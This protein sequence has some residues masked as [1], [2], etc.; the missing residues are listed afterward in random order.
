[1]GEIKGEFATD[2]EKPFLL[3]E[4]T[5]ENK[6]KRAKRVGVIC[7]RLLQGKYQ[8]SYLSRPHIRGEKASA[9]F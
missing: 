6:A 7:G 4:N 9:T 1:M 5:A 3:A 8:I 2:P